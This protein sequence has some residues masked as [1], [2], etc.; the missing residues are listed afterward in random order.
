MQ[1]FV[2]IYRFFDYEQ[3]P[4][5]RTVRNNVAFCP[6]FQFIN[7]MYQVENNDNNFC[8]VY[9]TVLVLNYQLVLFRMYHGEE[10]VLNT[11]IM[12]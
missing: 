3:G 10:L 11:Q 6:I 4:D 9:L 7:E 8:F 2:L 12:K 1:F 5:P